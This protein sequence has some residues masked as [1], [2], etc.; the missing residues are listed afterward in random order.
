MQIIRTVEK[1]W[2][3][4]D[5]L[6]KRWKRLGWWDWIDIKSGQDKERRARTKVYTWQRDPKTRRLR[7]PASDDVAFVRSEIT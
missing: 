5:I 6:T 7:S 2:V 3:A 1:G 4:V